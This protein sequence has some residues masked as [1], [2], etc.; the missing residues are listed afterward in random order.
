MKSFLAWL[1]FVGVSFAAGAVGGWAT[2]PAISGW[3][4]ELTKPG[5][6]PPGWVF[7]PVWTVLYAL[8]GSA[9]WVA[10][11]TGARPAAWWAF[12]TQLALNSLWSILFFGLRRPDLA[13][14]QI[15]VLAA[16]IVWCAVRFGE[17]NRLAGWMMTPNLAWVLFA[18]V[19]NGAIW[20][21]NR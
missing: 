8:M 18:S 6:N 20:W 1:G 21:L 16:A 13:L 17:A 2:A 3:Y 15:V 4:E 9:A 7:G 12:G 10:W 5:W 19:L 14:V 11:R